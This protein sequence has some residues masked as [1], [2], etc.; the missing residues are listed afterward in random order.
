MWTSL[1]KLETSLLIVIVVFM[2]IEISCLVDLARNKL[3]N[4]VA[5]FYI[6]FQYRRKSTLADKRADD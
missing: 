3:N 1:V 6:V 5:G 4:L 2:A